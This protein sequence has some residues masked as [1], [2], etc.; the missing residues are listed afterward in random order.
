MI[1]K[2]TLPFVKRSSLFFLIATLFVLQTVNAQSPGGV[3]GTVSWYKG[4]SGITL[5]AGNVSQWNDSSTSANN[6]TQGST[7]SQPVYTANGVNFNQAVTFSSGK[8][9][10]TPVTNL[11]SGASARTVFFVATATVAGGSNNSYVYAYGDNSSTGGGFNLGRPFGSQALYF[12]GGIGLAGQSTASFWV[13]NLPKLG[14]MTFNNPT[15]SFFDAGNAIGTAAGSTNTV[16]LANSGRISS[17]A[18]QSGSNVWFGNI[19]EIIVYPSAITGT[20]AIKVESYLALKYGIHKVGNYLSGTGAVV[21]DATANALYDNDI[22]GIGQDDASGLLQSQSN[23]S[24][25]GSGD[26]TG[27]TGKGNIII[28]NPSSLANNGF[29]VIGHD[30]GLLA[31]TTVSSTKRVQRIWKVQSTGNPGTVSLSYDI[32]GQTYSAQ[33]ASDYVLLVD[34]TGTGN[35]SGGSVVRYS[36]AA[37]TANKVSFNTVDLPTGAVFTFQTL[38]TPST[39]AT[40]IVF[41]GTTTTATT[42]NWTNGNGSSRAVFMYAGAS[43]SASPIDLTSYT[44]NTVFGLGT[45][46]G[47]TGWYCV[48]NGTGTT[49]NITGLIPATTYRVMSLEY[50]GILGGELYLSTVST[51]N[52]AEIITNAITGSTVGPGGII[53]GLN[54][55]LDAGNGTTA[56]GGNLTAWADLA[57]INTFAVSTTKPT[58]IS[59]AINFNNA[60]RFTGSQK[61]IGNSAIG[62]SEAYTVVAFNGAP[63]I[64][65]GTILAPITNSIGGSRYIFRSASSLLY[66]GIIPSSASVNSYMTTTPPPSGEYD[67]WTASGTGNVL[68]KNS[69]QVGTGAAMATVMTD[70]PQIGDRSSNDSKLNGWLAE[71]INYEVSKAG[72][73]RDNIE[74]YLSIKYGIK[75]TGNLISSSN[76]VVW[77]ATANASYDNDVFG[78]G[79]DDLS[80]LNQII[81]NSINTGSGDGTGQTGKGNIIISNPSSLANNGFLV[82]GHNTS[83]LTETNV[84]VGSTFTKRIQRIWKVQTTGSPGTVSLSY[85]LTGLAYSGQIANDYVLLV[86]PTGA[87][88]FSGGSVVKYSAAAITGNKVSFNTVALPTG[89]VFTFQTLSTPTVQAEN[90]VFTNTKGTTTTIS[91]TNGNGSSRA[92]FIHA[93]A[94][95]SALPVDLTTYTANTVFGTGTQIGATGWYCV[96]S[97]TGTTV[98]VTGLTALTAYQVMTVEYSGIPGAELYLSTVSTGNPTGVTTLNDIATLSNLAISQGTLAPVFA[99]GTLIYTASVANGV[100]SLTVT[101]TTTDTNATVTV[102]GIAVTSGSPSTAIALVAGPNVITTVVT[103]QDGI[104]TQTYTTTVTKAFAP[105]IITNFSPQNGPVGTTVTIA[106]TNFGAT[107]AENIVFFGATRAT[108]TAASA[109]SL[110]VTVPVGATYQ[111]ISVLNTANVLSGYSISSFITTFTPNKGRITIDDIMPKVDIATGTFM[112]SVTTGDFDGDGKADIALVFTTSDNISIYRNTSVSGTINASSF[113]ASGTF[114]TA[115]HPLFVK[116]A[117]M[118]G[119]GKLDLVVTHSVSSNTVSVLRNNSS[120]VG[121]IG[122]EA[123]QNFILSVST[124]ALAIGDLDGDG[125]PDIVTTSTDSGLA[126]VLRNI[127]SGIGNINFSPN[128]NFTA[129]SNSNGLAL[130]DLDGDGKLDMVVTNSVATEAMSIFLNTST[131]GTIN[132]GSKIGFSTGF[133][134]TRVEIGDLN[135]DGKPDIVVDG[136]TS[137]FVYVFQNTTAGIG[138]LSFAPKIDLAI[139]AKST[140]I[141]IGDFDG[142]GVPDLACSMQ[143]TSLNIFRNTTSGGAISFSPR[144]N[145]VNNVF[146][147]DLVISDLDG[148]GKSDLATVNNGTLSLFRNNPLFA[149]TTQATNVVFTATTGTTTTASWTNGNGSSRAVFMYAGASGSPLPVDLT[150]YTANAAFGTGTQIGSTGWYCVY[151]GTGTTVNITGLTAGTHYQLMVVEQNG[152]AGDEMYQT[153]VSTGNPAGITPFNNIATLSNL[154][155]SQGTLTPVFA[156]GTTTYTAIVGN[157]VTSLTVTPTTT[158]TNATVTVNGVTITSGN[159]SGAIALV[160]GPNIITTVVT[161]QNGTTTQTYTTT[162]TRIIAPPVITNFSPQTGPVGTTV[163]ITGANFGATIPQN[164]VFFGATQATVTAASTTSLTVTVPAG[165]TYEPIS[166][167]NTT[168]VLLG[169]SSVPFVTTFTPNKGNIT[170]DDFEPKVDFNVNTNAYSSTIGDFDGDG[171]PDIAV[172]NYSGNSISILRNTSSS[173]SIS[174]ASFAAKIDFTTATTPEGIEIGD[175]DGD[176]KIDLVVVNYNDNSMS[177]FRNTSSGIGNISFATRINFTTLANPRNAVVADFDGDGK[178]DL[179]LTNYNGNSISTFRNTSSGIG[180]INFSAKVDFSGTSGSIGLSIG[181]LD[182]DGKIDVATA[183]LVGQRVSVFRNISTTGV[184][185]FSPIV[186]LPVGLF[187]NNVVIG[188]LNNDGKPDLAVSNNGS[189][190]ISVFNNTSSGIGNINFD[191]KVDFSAA[192]NVTNLA[193]GDLDG[194]GKLDLAVSASSGLFSALRNTTTGSGSAITFAPKVDFVASTTVRKLKIGDL[195]GD[196]KDDIIATNTTANTIS[197]YRNNPLF[198]PT[199]QAINVVFTATTGTS[200]TASWTNGNGSSRAVFMYAGASGSPLP[201]DYTPYTANAAFGTGAQIGTS[202]WYCVYYGTGTTIN[203]TGLNPATLYQVMVVERNGSATDELYLSTVST[204]NP[205][206]VTT[207]S[208]VATLS[209]L[210]I[211]QGTLTP[212]FATG[213]TTYIATVPNAITSLTVTPT[214]TDSNATV[215]VNGVTV[216]SGNPSGAVALAVG[217]N[218]ITTVV[219]AQDGTTIDTY[220]ITVTRTAPAT[221]L[222][223]GTL[224]A[225]TTAYGTASASTSFN[226]SGTN[227]LDGILVTAPSGFEVSSDNITFTN[228]ITIGAA[229]TILSAPVYIRLKGNIPAGSYSGDVVLTSNSAVTINVA[230]VSSTV[231]PAALTVTAVDKNKVYGNANPTLTV[232]YSGFVNGDTVTSLTTAPTISTTALANSGVGSYPITASGAVNPNYTFN[233]VDGNL[234]VTVAS[235]TFTA[236]DKTRAYGVANPTFT[237]TYVGFVNGDTQSAITTPPIYNTTAVAGSSV[238][239]YPIIPTGA[240]SANYVINYVNGNLEITQGILTITADAQTKVYGVANPTLTVSYTGFANGETSADLTTQPT[241]TTTA[242]NTSGVGSYPITASGAAAANYTISYVAGTLTVTPANLAITADNQTKTYGSANPTFTVAYSGFVNGETEAVLLTPPIVTTTADASSSVGVY[243]L[244]VSGATAANYTIGYTTTATLTVTPAALTVTSV[245]KTKIYG[246]ANPALTVTY[247]GF[248]NGDIATDLQTQPTITTTATTASAVGSYPIVASGGADPNYTFTYVN[249]NLTVTLATLT[250]TAVDKT[251]VYGGANPTLTATYSGFVNGQTEADLLTLATITTTAT[252]A[253]AVGSYPIVASGGADPNY[254]FTYVDGNLTVTVA[255]L[256][257]TAVDKTKA[258]GAANPTLTATY[259]GFVNGETEADLLTLPTIS[260]TAVTASPVGTYPITASGAV[261]PNYTIN[262]V[263]GTFSITP[264]TLTITA[265]AKNKIYGDANPALTVSYTGFVNG[266]TATNLT[267]APTITTTAV[268]ASAAGTY[269]IVPS[270]AVDPNYTI[271][272]VNGILTV[273][274]ATL[275]ITADDKNKVYGDANPALTVS[276]SGFANGDTAASL[277]TPPT[278]S[279]TAT[280]ASS[281][282]T[283]PITAIGASDPNYIINYVNGTLT[284]S[285]TTLLTIVASNQSKTYGDANPTLTVSYVGFVNGDTEADLTTLPT[286]ST[287]AIQSSPAGTYPITASGAVS[288]N[289]TI[290]YTNGTLTVNPAALTVTADAKTKVYGDANPALTVTY[291]GFV[292]GDS[293]TSL[294]T[295]PTITTTALATSPVGSYPITAIGAVN[296]N[297]TFTYVAGNLAVTTA[298]LTVTANNKTKIYGDVDP[299]LTV[300]YLGFVNGDSAASLTTP[301]TITT[302]ATTG[303]PVGSYPI[304]ASGAVDSNYTINYVAGTLSITPVSLTV[305]ADNQTKVYGDAN[306]TLTVTYS[307]FVNG[308]SATSLTTAPTIITTATATSPVGTYPITASGAVSTNYTFTYVAGSLAVTPVTLTITADNQTKIYGNANPTLTVSY[309]GFVNGDSATSLTTAPIITTTATATSPVGTYPITASGAVSTNYTFTYVAGSLTVTPVTLTITADNQTKVYGNANPTLTVSYSGFVNGDSATSLTTAPTI[310]TTATA[311]SPVGTYPITASGAVSANYTFAYVAGSLTV[312]PVTLTITA[313]AKTKVYGGANPTL[314]VTYSGFVNGD[315]AASLTTAPT[316]TTTA[317]AIS[318]VGTYPITASGAVSA[319][320]TFTYVA[321]SLTVNGATLTITADD[322][323]KVYGD[324]NPTLTVSYSGFANGDTAASLLTQP[325]ISTTATTA[326]SVGTYPITA[327]GAAATNYIINYIDGTLTVS[328]TTLLTIV[329]NNQS[330]TYGDANP[331]LTVN[332]VGFV[333]GDTEADLTTLPTISTTAVQSS[334]AGTYPITASG[335]VSAN[336]TIAYTNGTLT[337]NPAALTV[338]ADTKTKVYGDAN[339]TLTVSYAGFVNGD[340]VASL[341]TA[342][343]VSTTALLGSGVGSYPI[344]AVGAVDPN[345]TITYVNGNLIINTANLTVTADNQTKTYG[346]ANPTFTVAYSGFVNGDTEAVLLIPP[347]VT[348]TADTSSSVGVYPLT[349]NGAIAVN[350]TITFVNGNLTVT[351][352]TL[353]ITADDKSKTYGSANPA[354]TASY[355]GFVNGD[356]AASLD[357]PATLSTIAVAGSPVGSYPIVASGA[358]DSNYTITFVNGNLTVTTATLTITADDK[359]KTYGSANPTLTASYTGFVN[360]DT[361]A[362]L[363]TPATLSTIAVTG[364]PVGSYPIVASGA[365]DSNYTITFVNGNLVVTTATLTITADDK[366]KTY[367]SANPALTASYTGFVNGDTSASLDTPATLST[368]AV[369]GSPVGSYPIV[370][371]GALDANYTITFVNG[372]LTVTTA[373]LTITADDQTKTYGSTNPTLT[374]SY[375]GFVNG[376]TAASL[377]TPATLST[378]AVIGSSVGTYPIVASGAIDSNYTI[379]FVNGNLTVTTTILTVTA[380]DKSKTYGSANPSL[381]ASYTGFVNGDTAASLDTPATLSTIALTGSPVGSYPIVASGA[382]DSNYTITFVNGNL[383]VTTATLTITADDKSKTYGS[384]NPALTA[385]YTGFVNGDTAASLDTPATLSTL[386]IAGSPVGSYPIVASGAIDSNYTITFVNGNLTVTT[387]NLTVTADDQTKTYGSANPALTASYTGFVNG[388]TAASLDTPATLSTIALTGSPVGS[389]PIVA[390]GAVDSNYTIT[391]VDGNLSVTT[392]TLTVTADDKSKTYGSANPALTASYTG[393]VN[394]DTAASLDTPA[395]LSTIAVTGSSVGSYPIVAS[396]ALDSNYTIT[397]VNG[398]LA[399]TTATLTITADDQT[400]TY[401]S[402]NP[403]LTASYTGFVNGDTAA[404]LDTPATLSTVAIAGSPVGSYPI[405]ASGAIDSNY[406]ITFVNGN[407]AVT[408]AT[409]TVTADDKSKTYGSANPSLTA[410]YTGFVNG[411]T[412]ASLDTPATLSTIAVAGSPVGAYPIVASGAV[413]SNYTITFVNG[414]LAVTTATLTITAD[415]QTKTYGSAN[416]AL[417][418][419]YAGFVNGDTA[420]S[421]DTPATLSTIAIAGSPVGSYPIVASGA[422]DSNYT[423]TFVNGNLTVTTANLTVTADDQTKTYGSANPALTASYTGFVNGDTSASLDTPAT[424]ST[425]AVTGS[426]VGS[427]P[428]VASGA[429]DSNYMITFVNG[430]LA[431]T[432]ATL[433][434]TAD[435]KSKTYGSANPVLTA[436]YTGF[437][438]GDTAVSLDT[439][440][441]FS[442]IAVTGSPVGSYPIVASGALDSNYTITFVNGNLAVTTA[443]LTITADDQTKTYGSANPALTASYTGFVNGDTA[444]SLDTQATLSTIAIAGSPVGS[445]PIVASGALDSNYTITFVNGNLTV[446]TATLTITADDKSKTY[447]SANPALTASYTGFVNG[448]TAASLDIPATLS[449]IAVTGSPVGSY[450]IL[451]NGALDSNYTITFVNGNLTVTTATL[452][453]TADDKTKV[454]GTVNPTL[455]ASYTGFVNG[456]TSASLDTPV[457]LSTIAVTTSPAGT[458]PI[459]ASGALDSNY[460]ITFVPGILT[461]TSSSSNNVNLASLGINSG[462]LNPAF[463]PNTLLYNVNVGNDINTETITVSSEDP[464]ATI[465]I[466]G[467]TI[468]NGGS[469]T[470]VSLATGINEMV[471]T[472]T[473]PDGTVTKTYILNIIKEASDIATLSNLSISNGVLEPGFESDVKDYNAAVKYDVESITVTPIVTDLS[474]HITVNGVAVANATASAPIILNEGENI[475]TTVVTAEDG[476]TKETYTITVYKAVGPDKVTAN[477]ILSPNGD[478]KNDFWEIKDILLYPNNTVTV[479]DRAGRIVYS[480][481]SYTNDWDGSFS[482]A[483]LN[484]DTYYYLIDLGD[485]LPRIK[486]FITMIRD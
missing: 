244:T 377:D 369:T 299:T 313:D 190:V 403:A 4:N 249:G 444:T 315:T 231:N 149:P 344:T 165:A 50:S 141:A 353:T 354:L 464:L 126:S 67:I 208:N 347:T 305:T 173:G 135:K 119:D 134:A 53:T 37:I 80:V 204:G 97:G 9:L 46:I 237:G 193:I 330:K 443:T 480:K 442:T 41:S 224:I 98:D 262:Y 162:V 346:S 250:V 311:T 166:V 446:T 435:D 150:V 35:F 195:D 342:P 477:N 286:I 319:N 479:Y 289:Y 182:G 194:D 45:Q 84:T 147:N 312:T 450:P 375:T 432:T 189:S 433:T 148:D 142:D 121:N 282:G 88:N 334:P 106:G 163:V 13:T 164:I 314:T 300:S 30:L 258:Y 261:D 483:P 245:D 397:F 421:L 384:T 212:V 394:G 24:N 392:A 153:A 196:G 49:A 308:D 230:T 441:T 251:K 102:N 32:T 52:P 238:G 276:Y 112:Q 140:Q 75:K 465:K 62:I 424:L 232:S 318:P 16:L 184:I 326:S 474:A 428:I 288:A 254:T 364:S 243:P 486:G 61:L 420:A 110:T 382:I 456:D 40:N 278:I 155:I 145:F 256:T 351:T 211:S 38:G 459:V 96:Y 78:I 445:Y 90:V 267:T 357:T 201:V 151:N 247:S 77:D 228:T 240:V 99:T 205:A 252:T 48:Y 457:A 109:T 429:I 279:T 338:T 463:S 422:I 405:V 365:I 116:A 440:A 192:T 408:T 138:N 214:T 74:S 323:N 177:I 362:S 355:T 17:I 174:G 333:N 327:N 206:A 25:T 58:V 19:S 217:P 306:P 197:V 310:T 277:L 389:Y 406:T 158:D 266:D 200:T 370:A 452:T 283:Y 309:S 57:G 386:A 215:K 8:Y 156:T 253:S 466:N 92:V 28:S 85:D 317:T 64:E 263:A 213:T 363:D 83:A 226:V 417:T 322:K 411:D 207:L 345:Y 367:G 301:P 202:G 418:A 68:R 55:W 400:K 203:I 198:A 218:I 485:N 328:A 127:S 111:P 216:T 172:T 321:G 320:Y 460:A 478:G 356:T 181:D 105:P 117:D 468:V 222:T 56:S 368:I 95:G 298:T 2:T 290:A 169:S 307:G 235:L 482:G 14:T 27:Q 93:G 3:S 350:Y 179:V 108:I 107:I 439:P 122:F 69:L 467:I 239:N 349:V 22:F 128:V 170:I 10:N 336:Y 242:T 426:P 378:I 291:S 449:T 54:L 451:A 285:A 264:V 423:I 438:N 448:D 6:A 136:G 391:F 295:A 11:P 104:T 430:N 366:S 7:G 124:Y 272:Y 371:S 187:A 297:Y 409:L 385:S 412:A 275:T 115:T 401:G 379:T 248:A 72:I 475:I 402:A 143:N 348:T 146:S 157:A 241:V 358:I 287:T 23:S 462:L 296:P 227:M 188:D 87:G 91:W 76:A 455:T 331:T 210:A 393:F 473:S 1:S 51:G 484:N 414:N 273:N 360:G 132:F 130:G 471:I 316:I 472:V 152:S 129:N 335:A 280:T 223:S 79:K 113:T 269:P 26:G 396:G 454:S 225:L 292:N 44:A 137:N 43:G 447:G 436:S 120:G 259:S 114:A 404:S 265:D 186:S 180:N 73:G 373:T 86:D 5:N 469:L 416:P 458:Y 268:T 139:D 476:T 131:N 42:I 329:A 234:T 270:A 29:L 381:T 343:S 413:D 81:S 387:A 236:D 388:D 303:S 39:Q 470:P 274:A 407:L 209:D 103:A 229:G 246:S 176:G 47:T 481:K 257:V 118:D 324:A 82:I 160:V 325:T 374:A 191:A 376:D 293:A 31:E 372:N 168:T 89:A 221:I 171:K 63:N 340:T 339:P 415:D 144:V 59:N 352:A 361:A 185:N 161:A 398:N 183:D 437:V 100:T 434:V 383:T 302:T 199:T 125:K 220:T 425:I 101:P 410:S 154:V 294:T 304:T 167:L 284:V 71:V 65:R 255:T 12:S 36:G 34:P 281:V 341:T 175:F 419:S 15:I 70:I 427:Y 332:Y 219:T 178:S 233:Y 380:D 431:V 66:V 395:T 18:D 133:A 337:V 159:P 21:W 94:S 271:V 453:I 399:V 359:S 20:N 60:I 123:P 461:V 33:T 260:T 390:S